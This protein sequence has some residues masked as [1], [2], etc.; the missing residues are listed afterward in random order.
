MAAITV[1]N[2]AIQN[3]PCRF[4]D[5]FRFE[6]T[7]DCLLPL[8]EDLEWKLIYIGSS[9]DEKYDQVLDSVLIGPLQPGTMKFVFETPPPNPSTIPTDE[10][11][12]ITAILLT[13]SYRDQ[14]FIKIGYYVNNEYTDPEMIE[15]PPQTP[16]VAKMQRSTLA[17]KPRITRL[18]ID[19][20]DTPNPATETAN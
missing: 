18:M 19:W 13:C 2:I 7:F 9:E 12:G 20:S 1:T 11:L 14:E 16:D 4:L 5:P 17:D 8:R 15:N 10:I 6:I 3:N